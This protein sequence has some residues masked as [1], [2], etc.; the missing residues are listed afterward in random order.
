MESFVGL[1]S[2]DYV[3]LVAYL[4]LVIGIGLYFSRGAENTEAYLLGGRRIAWWA[5]GLSY[6]VSVT[7]TLSFVSVPGEAYKEGVTLALATL[8]VPVAAVVT[9][10]IF[11]RFFFKVLAFTPFTY[12]ERRFDGRVRSVTAAMF[13]LTRLV[14]ISLVLY[15]CS[16]V[17]E[18]T[19]GW[20]VGWT[21][22]LIGVIGIFYTV[23]GGIRAVVWTDVAQ[24]VIMAGGLLLI[25]IWIIAGVPGGLAGI[26]EHAVAN[27]HFI[28][29]QGRN[30]LSFSPYVRVTLWLIILGVFSESLFFHSS[31]QISLQRLLSTSGYGQAKRALYTRLCADIPM[32]LW[33]WF[34]GLG[35]WVFYQH[36]PMAARPDAPDHALLR[37]IATELPRPVPGLIVA[38]L[39]AAVMSTLDSGMNSLATV[40]TKDFFARFRRRK[41]TEAE[42]V[43]FSKWMTVATGVIAILVA[44]AISGISEASETSV[45][46]TS[47]LWMGLNSVIPAAFLLAVFSRRATARHVLISLAVG[48]LWTAALIFWFLQAKNSGRET[49][50]PFYIGGSA[51]V[52]TV[53]VGVVLSRFARRRPDAELED[54]TLWTLRKARSSEEP[55]P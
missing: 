22:L 19:A 16:K 43:R 40:F 12:L 38:A 8:I 24:F 26:F 44:L 41:P 53:A 25:S 3:V 5:V 48:A 20:N 45:L 34:V 6:M 42:Q 10:V 37:F 47:W 13:S 17:F 2:L 15:S 21:I 55:V 33:L 14:Y 27:D 29:A 28:R 18:G 46:E 49:I 39:M 9:F 11:V 52:L 54:L 35:I 51:L 4:A 36:Q 32:M 31:D 50:S 1:G 30:F 7:S 23:L